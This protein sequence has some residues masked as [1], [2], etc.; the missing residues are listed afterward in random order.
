MPEPLS[1]FKTGERRADGRRGRENGTSVRRLRSRI[2]EIDFS[3]T[4]IVMI[5]PNR[6]GSRVFPEAA[7]ASTTPRSGWNRRRARA[8]GG[9]SRWGPACMRAVFQGAV[10]RDEPT[11][12]DCATTTNAF[13]SPTDRYVGLWSVMGD[14]VAGGDQFAYD[15]WADGLAR[16]FS[17]FGCVSGVSRSGDFVAGAPLENG[18]RGELAVRFPARTGL[19]T[20]VVVEFRT[21]SGLDAGLCFGRRP[22]STR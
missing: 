10:A 9:S 6:E 13:G 12:S 18:G 21:R 4:Q 16:G 5:V 1:S 2:P 19:K 8:A 20:A 15:K 22:D 14:P 3:A 7:R 17:D 11:R